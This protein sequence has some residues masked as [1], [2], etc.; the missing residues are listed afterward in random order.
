MNDHVHVRRKDRHVQQHEP[1]AGGASHAENEQ[2]EAP[3]HFEEAAHLNKE[4][5]GRP[6]WDKGVWHDSNEKARLHEVIDSN[7]HHREGEDDANGG[8]C[9]RR[10]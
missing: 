1:N 10:A 6:A 8:S 3:E 9:S 5:S 7:R 4:E 2:P